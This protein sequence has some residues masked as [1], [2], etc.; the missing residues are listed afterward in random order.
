MPPERNAVNQKDPNA[1]FLQFPSW[2]FHTCD[3]SEWIFSKEKVGDSFWDEILP[4]LKNIEMRT[5]GEILNDSSKQNH[6]I[7][8][9]ELNRIAQKRLEDMYVEAESILSLRLSGKHRIYGYLIGSVFNILW[10]D[11]DH[12]DN[13]T[14]VC[15]S[16]KKHT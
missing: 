7:E 5:W 1:Y 3:N 12:G 2:C 9:S 6:L 4:F 13:N 8:P 15:R 16:H 10:Y 14:C 11:N